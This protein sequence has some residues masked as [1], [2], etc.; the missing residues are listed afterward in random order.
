MK[1]VPISGQFLRRKDN[2]RRVRFSALVERQGISRTIEV[3]DFS[4][5]GLR[6]DKLTGLAVGD[7]VT[8]AFTPDVVLEGTIAW[9]VWHKAGIRFTRA[10]AEG[11]PAY[12]FLQE[13]AAIL[14]Q[15]RVRALGALAQRE[16]VKS[17][18]GDPA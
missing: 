13:Q 11:D 1:N 18:Q 17:R 12:T 5:A 8:I 15:A 4:N 10:L 16:A 3:I 6:I 7:H 14:E 9:L 2:R